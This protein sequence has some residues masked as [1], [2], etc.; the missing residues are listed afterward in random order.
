MGM[1]MKSTVSILIAVGVLA[2]LGTFEAQAQPADSGS[3][4]Q[5]VAASGAKAQKEA[6][7][8]LKRQI[9]RELTR[10]KGL[11]SSAITV[12]VNG[13]AVVLEGTVPEQSQMDLATRAAQGVAGVTSVKNALTL[14]TF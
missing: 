13:G 6:N 9:V 2:V 7:R 10:T 5:A 12:R 3:A 8:A 11:Q 14:S 4:P 1:T